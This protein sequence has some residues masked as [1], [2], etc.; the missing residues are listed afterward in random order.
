MEVASL[1]IGEDVTKEMALKKFGDRV[2]II[3]EYKWFL[4]DFI[5]FQYG[6]LNEK[7]RLHLSVIQILNK[8]EIKP[9][10]S[11]LEGVKEQYKDKV[12][13]KDK[14][15]DKEPFGKSENLLIVPEMLRVFKKHLPQYPASETKDYKPIFSIAN[16]LCEIG[17]LDGSPDLHAQKLLEAWEPICMTIAKDNFYKQKSLS[18]IS[19]HIQ[20]ITQNALHGKSNSKPDYGSQERA[21]EFDRLFAERYG[22]GG[23]ATSQDND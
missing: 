15:K 13:D 6:E 3:S 4:P 9:L 18:T 23:S 21:K 1:R 5:F 7:N 10:R 12:K 2:Q 16:Y 8:Y 11:P 22:K 19:N 17:K 14:D 20:E